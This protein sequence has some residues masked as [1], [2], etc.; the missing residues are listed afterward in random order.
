MLLKNASAQDLVIP[1]MSLATCNIITSDYNPYA[2]VDLTGED[3]D[4][5]IE[6][7]DNT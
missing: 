1:I 4:N 3:D 5:T 2:A 7:V 6:E